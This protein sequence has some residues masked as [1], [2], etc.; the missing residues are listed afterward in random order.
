MIVPMIDIIQ[1]AFKVPYP[2]YKS[3]F[4]RYIALPLPANVS[5]IMPR[6]TPTKKHPKTIEQI[7]STNTAVEF[8][9]DS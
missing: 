9:K 8:G 1:P 2:V 7:P 6:T 5:P 3:G 4:S